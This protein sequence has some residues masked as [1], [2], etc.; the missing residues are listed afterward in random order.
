MLDLYIHSLLIILYCSPAGSKS[1][2][3]IDDTATE[4]DETITALRYEI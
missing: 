2:L 4:P 1:N 3:F